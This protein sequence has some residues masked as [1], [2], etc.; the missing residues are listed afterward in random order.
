MS[1]QSSLWFYVKMFKMKKLRS[2]GLIRPQLKPSNSKYKYCDFVK[3]VYETQHVDKS[4]VDSGG[5]RIFHWG[6]ANLRHIC[7]SVKTY[8]K[9][10]ELD[11]V[12]GVCRGRPL[13]LPMAEHLCCLLTHYV[14][15]KR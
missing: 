8:A 13:D 14:R 11:P 10:K 15:L 5:S 4:E 9:T 3:M 6:G 2:S 1:D 12:G 7:F